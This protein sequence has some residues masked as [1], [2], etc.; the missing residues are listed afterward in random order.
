MRCL[1]P[2]VVWNL[3]LDARCQPRGWQVCRVADSVDDATRTITADLAVEVREGKGD[4]LLLLVD[5]QRAGAGMDGIYSAARELDEAT[6]FR[7]ALRR[8]ARAITLR[9]SREMRERAEQALKK[10]RLRSHFVRISPWTEFDFLVRVAAGEHTPGALLYLLGLWPLAEGKSGHHDWNRSLDI[11]RMFV[12]RLLAD[13]A[14]LS[15][16]QRIDAVKLADVSVQQRSLLEQFL[17]EV[18]TRSLL[19][20]LRHLADK[21]HLWIYELPIRDFEQA[22]YA[23]ELV[24]WRT[25]TGR[26]VKWSG[27]REGLGPQDPP[28]L[29][30]D[31]R[32]TDRRDYSRLEFRWKSKPQELEDGAV[33]YRVAILSDQGDELAT[34][35][36][37]HRKR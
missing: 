16:Y 3:A 36:V 26:I 17:R 31:P 29:I 18:E 6:L 13:T 32:A 4:P 2:E 9:H 7:S 14:G 5:A 35:V 30:I 8:A 19:E 23:L 33:E 11:S 1:P 12:A 27:L 20:A 22:V 21:P 37:R 28:R 34:S 15:A 10:A 24:P 25:A